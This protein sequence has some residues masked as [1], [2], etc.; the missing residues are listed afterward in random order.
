MWINRQR[1]RHRHKHRH[2]HRHTTPHHGER[3]RERKR[4]KRLGL[5]WRQGKIFEMCIKKTAAKEMRKP[6]FSF[7]SEAVLD[8][9]KN[10]KNLAN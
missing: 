1:H 8:T 2:R 10:R 5:Y 3:E 7:A 6:G 9:C 4:E